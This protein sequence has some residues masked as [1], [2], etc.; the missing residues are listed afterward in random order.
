M[1]LRLVV[2]SSSKLFTFKGE[3]KMKK[4]L[5]ST[6]FITITILVITI[7]AVVDLLPR[8]ASSFLFNEPIIERPDI[9]HNIL[10]DPEIPFALIGPRIQTTTKKQEIQYLSNIIQKKQSRLDPAIAEQIAKSIL[11]SSKK[12]GFP[13]EIILALIKRESTFIPTLTS[14]AGCRGLM[15]I[16]PP[17]HL[18]KLKS[19]GL[20][21]N[22]PK[23]FYITPNIDIGCQILREYYDV[24]N[25]N[26]RKALKRYV[27]GKH[28][29]YLTDVTVEFTS[30]I[31]SKFD[32]PKKK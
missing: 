3:N 31:L 4:M 26:I 32:S 23:I 24:E 20:T 13:P 28:D 21:E 2:F 22:S 12:Y 11:K 7:F 18:E 9:V 19:R 10:T 17:K 16:N 25:G 27:G 14:K 1:K 15:Q 30:L 8:I 5:Q 6:P 29:T